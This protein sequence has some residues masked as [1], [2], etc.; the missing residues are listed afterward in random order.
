MRAAGEGTTLLK[1]TLCGWLTAS[2]APKMKVR[3]LRIGPPAAPPN[4]TRWKG[5]ICGASKKFLA[6][7][8]LSRSKTYALPCK[9]LAPDRVTALMTEPEV[10]PYS[11]V[12]DVVT[13]L[14]CW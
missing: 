5:G 6:S 12:Y 2:Y 1:F 13:T 8:I 4:W 10:R 11:A 14:N 7:N 9:S 3:F